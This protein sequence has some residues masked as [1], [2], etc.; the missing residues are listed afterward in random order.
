M[1]SVVITAVGDRTAGNDFTLTCTAENLP[2]N[3]V[4]MPE[5]QWL[6]TGISSSSM[7]TLDLPFNPLRTSDA[8][9]VTCQWTF[10]ALGH[11]FSNQSSFH[12]TVNSKHTNT[13]NVEIFLITIFRE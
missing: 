1:P 8:S 12:L 6:G 10:T 3:L 5:L 13:V 9:V 11:N 7:D 2:D 4:G